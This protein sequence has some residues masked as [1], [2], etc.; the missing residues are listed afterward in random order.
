MTIMSTIRNARQISLIAA[1]LMLLAAPALAKKSPPGFI[2][3]SW[4][5]I[6]AN[7]TEVQIIDLSSLLAEMKASAQKAKEFELQRLLSMVQTLQVKGFKAP[8]DD[9]ATRKAVERIEKLLADDG[10]KQIVYVKDE[11]ETTTVSVR[12]HEER[13]VGLTVVSFEQGGEAAF[14]NVT[15]KLDLGTLLE[16]AKNLNLSKSVTIDN[17]EQSK[18]EAH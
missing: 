16:L 11:D 18:E 4:I 10:W 15:G 5:E 1:A 8:R 14:I 9:T 2:D 6:P 13:L 17:T 7:A 3:L 12:Y